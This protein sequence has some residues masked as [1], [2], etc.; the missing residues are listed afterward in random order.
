V[1]CLAFEGSERETAWQVEAA[2]TEIGEFR[3]LEIVTIDP[4]NSDSLYASLVEYQAAS[5]D[6]LTFQATLPPSRTAEFLAVANEAEVALQ[7]HAGNGIVIGHLSDHCTDGLTAA[8]VIAP[9]RKHAE[10]HGGSLVVLNCDAGW[11]QDLSVLGT[12][13]AD[14]AIMR[15]IKQAL[16]PHDVWNPGRLAFL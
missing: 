13:R 9:L 5:D 3:P 14:T 16:D 15:G 2:R 10:R 12:P 1:L 6:P 11:K 7:A 4:E 8:K